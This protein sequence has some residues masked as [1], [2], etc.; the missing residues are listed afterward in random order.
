MSTEEKESQFFCPASQQEWRKWLKQYHQTQEYVW[1]VLYKKQSN[2]PSIDWSAAVD[3]ALCFGWIDGKRKSLDDEKFIQ[4]FSQRKPKGTW[5]KINKEKVKR[6]IA[7]GR[8]TKA[9]LASIE[10]A[11]KNGSW[12]ILDDVEE[13]KVPPDLAKAFK[14]KPGSKTA[15]LS[16]SKSS[17][18]AILQWL[19]LAKKPETRQKRIDEIANLAVQNLKPKQFR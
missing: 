18:K 16:F 8:M 10:R 5:S 9:G 6:L 15:F 19:V 12:I 4:F 13:Y 2:R 1:L 11:K 3:E 17:Q 7:D 14:S